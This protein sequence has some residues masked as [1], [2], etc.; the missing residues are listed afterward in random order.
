MEASAAKPVVLRVAA[1]SGSIRK[2]SWH[3]G[4][5]RA[6][7]PSPVFCVQQCTCLFLL[8]VNTTLGLTLTLL[9]IDRQL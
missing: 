5:I 2:A 4:L 9:A 8:V 6:G 1:I 7:T 3:R